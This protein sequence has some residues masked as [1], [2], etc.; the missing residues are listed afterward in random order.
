MTIIDYR[1]E[2][3]LEP[4]G[5]VPV[6]KTRCPTIR[7]LLDDLQR[8]EVRAKIPRTGKVVLVCETGNRDAVAMRFLSKFGFTN[9]VGLTHGMRGWI[10]LDYPIEIPADRDAL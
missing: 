5:A 2:Y 10:K 9:V 4:Q 1:V 8:P 7:C 3:F 6:I